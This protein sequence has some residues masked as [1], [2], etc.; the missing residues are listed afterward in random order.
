MAKKKSGS[1]LLLALIALFIA[2]GGFLVFELFG[3]NTRSFTKDEY[4]YIRTGA[5]YEDVLESLKDEKLVRDI[6]GFKFVA[7]TLKLPEHIHAGRYRIKKGMSNYNI[8]RM[9]RAGKQE[10]VRLVVNRLR[11]KTD[12]IRLLSN[13]LEADSFKI[14]ELLNDAVFLADLGVDTGTMMAVVMQDTYEFYW[15][16]QPETVL[17]KIHK[18]HS[19]YWT[20]A[21]KQKAKAQGITPIQAII[22]ASIVDEETNFTADKPNI[23]SVYL[24]R[25]RKGMKL[26]ADPTVKFAIGDFTIK[27]IAGSMLVYDSPYNTYMY[28]GLPPGPICTPSTASINAVL[29]APRSSYLYFCAKDDFSGRTAFA[30]TFEEQIRNANAYHRA[31]NNRGIH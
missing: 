13:N 2:I 24:N 31:L 1:R 9:L 27:R 15:N 22:V 3:P 20:P 21:R 19:R 4:L 23:A 26:Q 10:P 8:V 30:S 5:T 16:A 18:N 14:R 29:D 11:T 12:F 25:I 28:E 17:R 6:T 7:A